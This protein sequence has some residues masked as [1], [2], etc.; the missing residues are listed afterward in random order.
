ML[1]SCRVQA[2]AALD[3]AAP[4]ALGR[5]GKQ[6]TPVVMAYLTGIIGSIFVILVFTLTSGSLGNFFSVMFSLA[7]S[8]AVL[9]YL[10]ALPAVITL[11]KKFPDV[12]RPFVVPGGTAGLWICAVVAEISIVLTG[13]TLLWPGLIDNTLGQKYDIV[14][15]WGVS[16]AFFELVTLG[17]FVVIILVSIGLWAWGRAESKG[18]ET[19]TEDLIG[20]V[21]EEA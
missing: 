21:V 16:R 17:T 1:G 7:V 13:F 2:M 11:R 12:H 10:F 8:T 6:G 4:R 19:T 15:N 14:S 5:F 20:G 3:G 9:C 18:A